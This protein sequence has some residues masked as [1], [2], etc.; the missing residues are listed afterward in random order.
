MIERIGRGR[1]MELVTKQNY[2]ETLSN[3][4]KKLYHYG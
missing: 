3:D 2:E 4:F 1:V